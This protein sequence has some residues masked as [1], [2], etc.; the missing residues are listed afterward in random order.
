MSALTLAVQAEVRALSGDAK[1]ARRE[2]EDAL[3]V[4][5]ELEDEPKETGDLRILA[6]VMA[7]NGEKDEAERLLREV[8]GRA[9]KM[10]QPLEGAAAA[11][12]L[13]HLLANA[14]RPE[15]ARDA[16]QAA[17]VM[18]TELG[19]EGEVRHLDELIARWD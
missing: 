18:Y 15:D 3:A 14:D 16:A 9:A 2:I 1:L 19:A 5:R 7:A 17:R 11:R 6:R 13:A 12:D 4:H 8:I 10:K